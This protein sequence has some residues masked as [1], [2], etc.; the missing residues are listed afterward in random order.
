MSKLLIALSFSF[1]GLGLTGCAHYRW[2]N[3]SNSSANFNQDKWQCQSAANSQYPPMYHQQQR[4]AAS[5]GSSTNCTAY[6]NQLNCDTTPNAPVYQY[7]PPPQ[8]LNLV[9]RAQA[10]ESCLQARGWRKQKV[11]Q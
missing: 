2:V 8:D 4:Q 6:G 3:D 1:L 7:T 10:A 5:T 9:P 11:A